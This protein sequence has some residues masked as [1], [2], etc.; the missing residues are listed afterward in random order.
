MEVGVGDGACAMKGEGPRGGVGCASSRYYCAEEVRRRVRTDEDDDAIVLIAKWDAPGSYWSYQR[1]SVRSGSL[2]TARTLNFR[3]MRHS[4]SV[5]LG[6]EDD[7]RET[8][9]ATLDRN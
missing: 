8:A 2:P 5:E 9:R 1:L 4:S 6:D 7:D 3:T